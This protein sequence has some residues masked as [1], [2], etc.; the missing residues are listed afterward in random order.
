MTPLVRLEKVFKWVGDG[1][2]RTMI[3]NGIDLTIR[4]GEYLAITGASGC[5][6]STLLHV[7]GLLEEPSAGSVHLMGHDAAG[8]SDDEAARLRAKCIGFVYQSFNLL[9]YLNA[10]ENIALPMGYAGRADAEARSLGLL[11]KMKLEHRSSAYPTTLSGGE[12]QRVAIARALANSPALI[13][14]DEPTGSLD[15][16]TGAQVMDLIGELHRNGSTVVVVTHD[17]RVARRARRILQ[18]KDGRLG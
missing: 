6:K 17:D 12:R 1:E 5:G 3:L 14:A 13:L 8:L 9:P 10:Q 16:K 2:N 15:S 4:P 11:R 18:M 7:I